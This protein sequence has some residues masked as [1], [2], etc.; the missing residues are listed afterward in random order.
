MELNLLCGLHTAYFDSSPHNLVDYDL[1]VQ[2]LR[3]SKFPAKRSLSQFLRDISK[4]IFCTSIY[5]D[6]YL[7]SMCKE[8]PR[9]QHKRQVHQIGLKSLKSDHS[10]QF[11]KAME[12]TDC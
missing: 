3:M 8:T 12:D 7:Y 6:F 9:H 2:F 1:R 10:R 4:T 5:T 11:D